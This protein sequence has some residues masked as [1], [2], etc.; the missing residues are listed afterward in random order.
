[1]IVE[2][3]E[4]KDRINLRKHKVSFDEAA[5]VFDDPPATTIDDP[6][7]SAE[8]RRFLTTGTTT[9]ARVVIVSHT[10]KRGLIRVISA[11]KATRSERR[12][13]EEGE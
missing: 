9:E 1:M 8:E 4:K 6:D 2:W 13:Y 5:T 12:V 3:D 7:H 11:R 10:Y